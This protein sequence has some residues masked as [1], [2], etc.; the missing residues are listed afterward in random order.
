MIYIYIY[1]YVHRERFMYLSTCDH[2]TSETRKAANT[3]LRPISL[4]TL[5][6]LR[7]LD[8]N[9]PGNS[10]W[11]WEFHPLR[12]KI[13]LE[14]NPLKSRMLVWRLAVEHEPMGMGMGL[15]SHYRCPWKSTLRRRRPVGKWPFGA[16]TQGLDIIFCRRIAWPRLIL[17]KC[18]LHRHRYFGFQARQTFNTP[19][20]Y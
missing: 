13:M 3:L 10:L 15:Y 16:P 14:S 6:L 2:W 12:I 5:S 11:A 1:I 8:S 19:L 20:T 7:L 4:L 9:F 18:F 17:K